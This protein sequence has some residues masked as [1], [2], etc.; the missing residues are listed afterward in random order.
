MREV[1]DAFGS[2]K[3]LQTNGHDPSVFGAAEH[4]KKTA[5]ARHKA[6]LEML[7]AQQ[8]KPPHMQDATDEATGTVIQ[9]AD[10]ELLHEA[11]EDSEMLGPVAFAKRLC[12]KAELTLEQK[13]PVALIVRDMQKAYE[14]EMQRRGSSTE[15]QSEAYFR[16]SPEQPLLPLKGRI[17]R[18][19][20]YGGGGC[21]KTRIINLVLTP[22]SPILRHKGSSSYCFC[23]QTCAIDKRQN[24]PFPREDSWSTVAHHAKTSC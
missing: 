20:L 11:D 6:C 1:A 10:V 13:G 4:E 16:R 14:K 19:L 23:E 8:E 18:L 24:K 17:A 5:L 7:R 12:D 15:T 21:G 22:V 9:E 2:P 3:H